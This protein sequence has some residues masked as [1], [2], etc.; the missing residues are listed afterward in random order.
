MG[1]WCSA[2]AGSSSPAAG[3]RAALG[4]RDDDGQQRVVHGAAEAHAA[5]AEAEAALAALANAPPPPPQE[6]DAWQAPPLAP[7]A[8]DF[9]DKELDAMHG[10]AA[11]DRGPRGRG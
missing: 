10:L 2:P 11:L 1:V 3:A 4:D 7:S 8:S 9:F 5:S 6:K